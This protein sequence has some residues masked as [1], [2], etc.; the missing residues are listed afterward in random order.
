MFCHDLDRDMGQGGC[1]GGSRGRGYG[2]ICM[3][4]TDLL[5]CARET[6]SI[7]KQFYSNKDLFK[8]KK[9][10]KNIPNP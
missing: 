10:G 5:C 2:D 4:M 7:V 6:N 9:K 1:E 3:H 8:Q